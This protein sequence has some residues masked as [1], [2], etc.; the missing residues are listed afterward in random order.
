[1]LN[2]L[3]ECSKKQ[4][5]YPF[6]GFHEFYN[7]FSVSFP[8]SGLQ[9]SKTKENIVNF[10]FLIES[11]LFLKHL[12]FLSLQIIHQMRVGTDFHQAVFFYSKLFW[13]Q[14]L[15]RSTANS[16]THQRPEMFKNSRHS[17]FVTELHRNRWFAHSG[18][19][20]HK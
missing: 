1:M 10:I 3:Y 12:F 14:R 7:W 18:C 20:P 6:L 15:R 8:I 2:K 16:G 4:K 11:A 17:W 13:L 9:Q 5:L 19:F